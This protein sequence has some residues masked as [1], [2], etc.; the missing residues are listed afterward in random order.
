MSNKNKLEDIFPPN[1]TAKPGKNTVALFNKLPLWVEEP[2][3]VHALRQIVSDWDRDNAFS[4]P[5]HISANDFDEEIIAE[6]PASVYRTK[7]GNEATPTVLFFHGGGFYC[8]LANVH[9]SL[10]ANII[11]KIPCHGV[12]PHYPLAPENKAPKVI[13]AVTAILNTLLTCPEEFGLTNNLVVVGYSSGGNLAWNAVL[14]LLNSS[15]T[16]DRIKQISHLILMSPWV[17]LSMLTTKKPY[18]EKQ[19]NTDKMIQTWHA[20]QWRDWYLPAESEKTDPKFSP[21]YRPTIEMKGMPPTTVIVGEVERLLTD[22]IKTMQVLK[23]AGVC[24]EL[25]VLEGQSH[26]HSAHVKLRDGVF[27]ADIISAVIQEKSL[28]NLKGED[29]LGLK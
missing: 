17:D 11:D 21:I 4:Y 24:A 13:A 7:G 26:N 8:E 6:V 18:Y 28:N 22:S 9:K 2:L 29:G 12:L 10:M 16:K 25:V 14:N 20:E 23:Q 19:Q 3:D 5:K 27:T 15:V 1:P